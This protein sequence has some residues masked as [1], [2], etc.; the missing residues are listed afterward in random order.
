MENLIEELTVVKLKVTAYAILLV[1]WVGLL[2]YLVCAGEKDLWADGIFP[3]I[4]IFNLLVD[5]ILLYKHYDKQCDKERVNRRKREYTRELVPSLFD[6]KLVEAQKPEERIE[7]IRIY[8]DILVAE[9]HEELE[10]IE[11]RYDRWLEGIGMRR[12]K[13]NKD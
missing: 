4:L 7:L 8:R 11:E 9:S 13:T 1:L 12:I 5:N 6:P 10:D 2:I 3:F